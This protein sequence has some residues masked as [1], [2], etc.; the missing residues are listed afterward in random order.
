MVAIQR[1]EQQRGSKRGDLKPQRAGLS[2]KN[3]QPGRRR[4]HTERPGRNERRRAVMLPNMNGRAVE[5]AQSGEQAGRRSQFRVRTAGLRPGGHHARRSENNAN[6]DLP[7]KANPYARQVH[8]EEIEQEDGEDRCI[9]AA[10]SRR[11][12]DSDQREQSDAGATSGH[13]KSTAMAGMEE[14]PLAEILTQP[15]RKCVEQPIG[16]I[17]HP[18]AQPKHSRRS[19]RQRHPR[20]M[21]KSPR[22]QHRNGGRVKAEQVPIDKDAG[23]TSPAFL[24]DG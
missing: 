21:S 24:F 11:H 1:E 12:A 7:R 16:N 9:L 19:S 18:R 17:N 23:Q 13:Q 14:M 2:R 4:C 15:A 5:P 22:P 6:D 10:R 8:D 20:R 3:R